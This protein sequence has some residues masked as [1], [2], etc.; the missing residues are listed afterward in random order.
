MIGQPAS[1]LFQSA[2][3]YVTSLQQK[4]NQNSQQIQILECQLRELRREQSQ[5]ERKLQENTSHQLFK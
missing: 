4:F 3:E 5:I 2:E 1:Y